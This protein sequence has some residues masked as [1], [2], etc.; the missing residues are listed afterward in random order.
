MKPTQKLQ[1]TPMKPYISTL[2]FL[3]MPL[4]TAGPSAR[5]T[6]TPPNPTAEYRDALEQ[7]VKA[8]QDDMMHHRMDQLAR[9]YTPGASAALHASRVRAQYLTNWAR[10]RHIHWTGIDVTV[11][12]PLTTVIQPNTRVRFYALEREH[13]RY[14]YDDMPRKPLSFGIASRHHLSIVRQ[15]GRWLFAWDDFTNPVQPHDMAG[16]TVPQ[17]VGGTPPRHVV[18]SPNRRAALHYANT[19]C[20]DAPGCGNNQR[21]HS[22]YKDYNLDGGDCTNWISQVLYAGG[23][24]M[25]AVWNYNHHVEEGTAAWSNAGHLAAFLRSSGRATEFARGS[26]AQV[27]TSTSHW[28]NGAIETLIPGDLIS[29]EQRGRIQHTAVVVG[30][31]PKGVVLT[32][33]HTNDRY[34]VPWDFGWGDKTTF[35]LWH[36]HYPSSSKPPADSRSDAMNVAS[37]GTKPIH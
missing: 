31:D 3:L 28:P 1:A 35:F 9:L 6:N 7:L 25:T 4:C 15:N 18:L 21:Y 29:Y 13:Y 16:Q 37:P 19:F 33:T 5:P 32:N 12:A 24:S 26:Y 27:T 10:M 14:R 17:R 20:G 30:Y 34:R 36:V 11:R 2:L 22:G 23:F 8:Q